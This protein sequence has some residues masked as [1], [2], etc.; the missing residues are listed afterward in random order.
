MGQDLTESGVSPEHAAL[1]LA[2]FMRNKR[3]GPFFTRQ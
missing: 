3:A 2:V 1:F